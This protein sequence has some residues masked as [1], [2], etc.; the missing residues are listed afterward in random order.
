NYL[1]V[2]ET[3]DSDT[4]RELNEE[5][6][7]RTFHALIE[8]V[9]QQSNEKDDKERALRN[10]HAFTWKKLY[11]RL[12]RLVYESRGVLRR[13]DEHGQ[14]L[15]VTRAQTSAPQVVD[16][17]SLAGM[18]SLQRFVVAT[19]FRQLVDART[20]AKAIPGLVYLVTLDELNRFAPKGAKDP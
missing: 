19:I 7:V 3:V 9:N 17:S 5:R 1:T 14:P 6:R 18:P 4:K 11:R 2:E 12:L 8:W 16:L 13:N 20:G 10:H 15:Q